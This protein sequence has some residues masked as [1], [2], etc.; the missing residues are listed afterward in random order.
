LLESE[1]FGHEKGAFTGAVAMKKGKIELAHGGSLFLDEIG[2][3]APAMQAKLLRVLQE[4]ELERVGGTRSIKTD[5]RLVAATNKNLDAEVK[6]GA[7]RSDLYYRL[8]VVSATLPALREHGEDI[9]LLAEY[10]LQK[11]AK[12]CQ[13]PARPLSPEA[14]ACLLA[15][16]WPG[17]VRELEN[18]ME[19][20]LVLGEGDAVVPEDLPEALLESDTPAATGTQY[21]LAITDLKKR[22]ILDALERSK[23]NYTAA[24]KI[25]GIH[26]NYL[27]RLMRNLGLRSSTDQ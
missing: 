2:E 25:L 10:F 21:H 13:V 11:A 15:Y 18:A 23:G 19:R 12:R 7:F 6:A 24:A 22:L 3:L 4:R 20:A 16:R 17:N 9:P 1:L 14:R 26:P 5:F 8:N 27:H